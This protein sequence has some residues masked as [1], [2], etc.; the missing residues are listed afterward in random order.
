MATSETVLRV[1][2]AAPGDIG[3][4]RDIILTVVNDWNTHR[5]KSSSTRLEMVWW[6]NSARPT[7]GGRPQALINNQVL[8]DADIV[9]GIF[10][11]RFGTP[12]GEADSG[13]EEEIRRSV[14]A[15]KPV[16]IYFCTRDLPQS[17]FD[18]EQFTQIQTFKRE[19]GGQGLYWEYESTEEFKSQFSRHLADTVNELLKTHAG[20]AEM[21][22]QDKAVFHTD[23]EAVKVPGMGST[24][25][26]QLSKLDIHMPTVPKVFTDRDRTRFAES[27]YKTVREFFGNALTR[28]EQRE[29][30]IETDICEITAVQFACRVYVH[31][32]QHAQCKIWFGNE[33]GSPALY[34]STGNVESPSG[35]SY[36]DWLSVDHDDSELFLKA[37]GM[38]FFSGS[39][40]DENHLSPDQAA[41]YLWK[42]LTEHIGR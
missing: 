16:M 37:S 36:N 34:Y 26:P 25:A 17:S 38:G 32:E 6:G 22:T 4:E 20:D 42:R 39:E 23:M 29:T 31:G 2:V 11:S 18:A 14:A 10:W 5:G 1:F 12:T 7:M 28:L 21:S 27:A 40:Q 9:V 41:Q 24:F 15:G 19:M 8:D 3:D 33:M 30:A 13:T 35:G